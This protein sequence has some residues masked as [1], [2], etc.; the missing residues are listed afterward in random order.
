MSA[1]R[2]LPDDFATV[3]TGRSKEWACQHY[4]AGNDTVSRWFEEAGL[5]AQFKGPKCRPMPDDFAAV[6][7]TLKNQFEVCAHYGAT[8]KVV[9]RWMNEAGLKPHQVQDRPVPD[10]FAHVAPSMSKTQLGDRY[11]VSHDV[12][13][14]WLRLSGVKA[15]ERTRVAHRSSRLVPTRGTGRPN[16]TITRAASIYDI[17]ANELRRFGPVF[18]CDDRGIYRQAGDYWRMG[19]SILTPD[20]LLE[21]A[22]RKR[23]A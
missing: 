16:L 23:A 22:A 3:A 21:R 11:K 4:K 9:R 15:M 2:P 7:P 19:W 12:I 8:E 17:A 10:D 6:F 18:R 5:K 14:R 13:N 20:E 1:K